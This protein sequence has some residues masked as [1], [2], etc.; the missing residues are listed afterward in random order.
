MHINNQVE[1]GRPFTYG[2]SIHVRSV[3]RCTIFHHFPWPH[4]RHKS[5]FLVDKNI[6]PFEITN[7]FQLLR[8][9]PW[10]RNG[11]F[12]YRPS[13]LGVYTTGALPVRARTSEV[14]VV[15]QNQLPYLPV[16]GSRQGGSRQGGSTACWPTVRA[17][18]KSI[19]FGITYLRKMAI[20]GH[21]EIRTRP[22]FRI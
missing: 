21:L 22:I 2:P 14:G 9:P 18:V 11:N 3:A 10:Y 6:T 8:R 16:G 12:S 7:L 1:T 20:G 5:L 19:D 17:V 4:G 15:K 13:G